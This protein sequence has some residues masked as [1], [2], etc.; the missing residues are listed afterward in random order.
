MHSNRRESPLLHQMA[1]P[2]GDD[3]SESALRERASTRL[4][5]LFMRYGAS[6][7]PRGYLSS[8]AKLF[9]DFCGAEC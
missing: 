2:A 8:A 4:F 6:S 7:T 5:R 1:R 9:A 3:A